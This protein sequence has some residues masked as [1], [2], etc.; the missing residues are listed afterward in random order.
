M[1]QT[2]CGRALFAQR[3]NRHQGDCGSVR[4]AL[5]H[6]RQMGNANPLKLSRDDGGLRSGDRLG[7]GLAE[8]WAP[9][10]LCGWCASFTSGLINVWPQRSVA[11]NAAL[12]TVTIRAPNRLIDG[13]KDFESVR[14]E[15]MNG[16]C[17]RVK[18]ALALIGHD[19]G[20][21]RP[22]SAWPLTAQQQAALSAF[23]FWQRNQL[24]DE[25]IGSALW[26]E[27]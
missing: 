11:I 5:R 7:G 10:F 17:D 25:P 4:A 23:H 14:A 2:G 12:A 22:P 21:A 13:M 15:E 1:R 19:C 20:P 6:R 26:C 24:L 3:C 16:R 27:V 18:A 9:V 8:I